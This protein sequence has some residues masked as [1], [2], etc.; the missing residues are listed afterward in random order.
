MWYNLLIDSD[1]F[2]GLTQGE[3]DPYSWTTGSGCGYSLGG[4]RDP[5]TNQT[6]QT[7]LENASREL[8]YIDEGLSLGPIDRHLLSKFVVYRRF[9]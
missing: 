2:L 1:Q 3:D 9:Q 5:Y 6:T 7:I 4:Q 8:Y